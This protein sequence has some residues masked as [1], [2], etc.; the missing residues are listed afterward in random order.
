[1]RHFS[2][3]ALATLGMMRNSSKGQPEPSTLLRDHLGFPIDSEQ[4]LFLLTEKRERKLRLGA[5]ELL[6]TA[7]QLGGW[8]PARR[9]ASLAGLA[10]STH[11]ALPLTRCWLRSVY[12]DL[13]AK[14][15]W[16]SKVKL[17]R[18]SLRS[19]Q[20]FTRLHSLLHVGRSIWL[21]PDTAVGHV[22]TGPLGWGGYLNNSRSVPPVAGFRSEAE[23]SEHITFRELRAARYYIE[24][25]L[26]HLRGRRLLPSMRTTRRWW[27]WSPRSPRTHHCSWRRS[28]FL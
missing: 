20:E 5:I 12:S 18:Q 26:E 9:A 27:P 17:S 19:L 10:R 4:G 21:K 7:A 3:K 16:S 11:L 2:F 15:S 13:R 23:A 22:D 8:A 25:Y 24:H 6:R 1:M 28:G 14:R